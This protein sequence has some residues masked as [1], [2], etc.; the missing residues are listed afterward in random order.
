VSVEWFVKLKEI[1]SLGKMRFSHLKHLQ[2][3]QDRVA[4]IIERKD[5]TTSQSASLNLE[6]RSLQQNLFETEKKIQLSSQQISNLRDVGGDQSKIDAFTAEVSHLE[7]KGLELLDVIHLKK[8]SINENTTF[9]KG[10]EKTLHEISTEV[11]G[12]ITKLNDEIKKIDLRLQLLEDELPSNFQQT[13]TR[14]KQKNLTHGP[15]TRTESGNCFFCRYKLSKQ[16]E[17]E[18]DM[19]QSLKICTQCGRIFLPYGA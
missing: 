13:Y 4:K 7:D 12:E 18:I 19:L 5:L 6:V 1:D 15:F 3:Q 9:L 14:T 16:E 10:L 11:D 8:T 17:I 2:E